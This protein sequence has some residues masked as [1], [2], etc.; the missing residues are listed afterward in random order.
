MN[1]PG[2]QT[3]ADGGQAGGDKEDA[4]KKRTGARESLP[5]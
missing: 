1:A 5:G 4:S 3:M 2:V